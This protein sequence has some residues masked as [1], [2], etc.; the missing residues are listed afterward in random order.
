MTAKLATTSYVA[1]VMMTIVMVQI[2][3]SLAL[4]LIFKNCHKVWLKLVYGFFMVDMSHNPSPYSL[5]KRL[6]KTI[7]P[8]YIELGGPSLTE[9]TSHRADDL[10]VSR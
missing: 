4:Q 8:P 5:G 2:W 1:M 6:G 7:H 3:K 9:L 10:Q